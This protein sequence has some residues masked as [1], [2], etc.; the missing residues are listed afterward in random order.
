MCNLTLLSLSCSFYFL[1]TAIFHLQVNYPHT[2]VSIHMVDLLDF[3]E[4]EFERPVVS[5]RYC[6]CFLPA[7]QSRITRATR[8]GLT[9]RLSRLKPR[10]LEKQRGLVMNNRL[11]AITPR[12]FYFGHRPHRPFLFLEIDDGDLYLLKDESNHR[13][14]ITSRI[15]EINLV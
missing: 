6:K 11:D 1:I 4:M 14:M 7:S 13:S 2:L 9:N 3:T 12:S 5:E 15:P 8:V 10:A